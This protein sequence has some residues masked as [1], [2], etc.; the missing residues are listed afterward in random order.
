MVKY[1]HVY[2]FENN[3]DLVDKTTMILSNIHVNT[4]LSASKFSERMMMRGK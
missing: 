1:G 2:Y 3:D 4:G